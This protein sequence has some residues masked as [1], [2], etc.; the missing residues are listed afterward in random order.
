[1]MTAIAIVPLLGGLSL[2]VDY[3]ELTRQK[4]TA[5][6]ALDAANIAA[7]RR[8][9][10]GASEADVKA[11]ATDFFRANLNGMAV[12]NT[13]LTIVLPNNNTGGGTMKMTAALKY[14]P[15]FLPVL[16]VMLGE[17]AVTEINY[18]EVSEVKLKNTLEVALVLDNSG[19][20]SEKGGSS[21][22]VRMDLLKDASKQLV[23]TLAA[24]ANQMK[25]VPKPVQ[26]SLVPFAASVNIGADKASE[27]WMDTDGI[28]PIHH[29]NFDWSTMSSS[30]SSTKY[31]QQVGGIWYKKGAGWGTQE[32][33]KMTRFTL[34]N[35]IQRIS[36]YTFVKTG[37][38]WVCTKTSRGTCTAGYYKDVGYNQ[39]NYAPFAAWKGCVEGRPYPY[40]MNDTAP[41][42]STP[43]TLFVPMFAPDES[44]NVSSYNNWWGDGTSSSSDATRQ[45]Y[46]PKYYSQN[47]VV[48]E[49]TNSQGVTIG[50]NQSCTTTPITPLTDV[51]ND[52]GKSSIKNAID[53]M[54]PLGGTNVPEAMAW[55]WRT[56]SSGAPFT[57]GRA[58]TEKGND[59][60]VIVVTDGANTYYPV[61]YFS[62]SDSAGNK[63]IYSS[64]GY[65]G[66]AYNGGTDSRLFLGTANTISRTTHTVSNYSAAMNDHFAT[67]CANAKAKNIMVMTVAVDL[68]SKNTDEAKQIDMLKS[69][70]SDSRFRKDASGK[71]VKLFWNSTGA[72]LSTDFKSIGDE[73]SNLRI[74]S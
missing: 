64:E 71:A 42:K 13:A 43:A 37:Q 39:A 56:V 72:S 62:L 69:C 11:Y 63:S 28:S 23:D 27:A 18:S 73:L 60:V 10:E 9:L 54:T 25:Q 41:S 20:M 21:G 22:K 46:M 15:Y 40:N 47:E 57:E 65:V 5:L 74:V 35:D 16:T 59:K 49:T 8:Y 12:S 53:A 19:S 29:E 34:Y 4:Q 2:A 32:N 44:G 67:L 14:Q 70:A 58:D 6:N 3:A 31:V 55:G 45:K 1:M 7:A 68:D 50:P 51:S 61:S 17:N 38:E 36:G 26:F 66:K 52:T 48:A 24:Q 30:Y 33:Q